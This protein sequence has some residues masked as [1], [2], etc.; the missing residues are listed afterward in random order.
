MKTTGEIDSK[1]FPPLPIPSSAD[2]RLLCKMV[3][4]LHISCT[5]PPVYYKSTLDYLQYLIQCKCEVNCYAE[6]MNKNAGENSTPEENK[7]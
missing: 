6:R 2:A 5:D 3:M 1:T 7:T 4:Y